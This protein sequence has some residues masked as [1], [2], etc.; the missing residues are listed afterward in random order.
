MPNYVPGYQYDV[1]ISYSHLNNGEG[2]VNKFR[3]KLEARLKERLPEGFEL[4]RD[5]EELPGNAELTPEITDAVR[6]TAVLVPVVS[7]GFLKSRW[8]RQECEEFLKACATRGVRDCV[9]PVRYDDVDPVEYRKVVGERVGYEFFARG[10]DDKYTDTLQ[11]GSR[12]F[13]QSLNTLR[14]EIARQLVELKTRADSEAMRP[15]AIA[16]ASAAVPGGAGDATLPRSSA[17]APWVAGGGAGP[18][19]FLAAPSPGLDDVADQFVSFLRGYDIEVIRP[20]PRFYQFA[21]YE[22]AFDA[23]LNRALVFVQLLG[24]RFDPHPDDAVQSWDRWQFLRAEAARL[25]SFRWFN[26]HNR[27]GSEIDVQQLDAD[28]RAFVR[29]PGVWDFQPGQF[30]E[31]VRTEVVQRFHDLRQARRNPGGKDWQPLIVLRAER[32]DQAV[33]D[34]IGAT[35]RGLKC[36]W[37]RVPDKAVG[38]F[39]DFVAQYAGNGLLVVY[40]ACPGHWVLTRLQELRKFLQ[41][42]MG[43]R[44]ACGLWRAPANDED[45]LNCSMDGLFLIEPRD[46]RQLEQFV[47]AM[48]LRS[49]PPTSTR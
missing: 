9:F 35:L 25:P 4:F 12:G 23:G 49:Q 18:T 48:R 41:T 28:H 20:E 31:L 46:P 5:R 38:S 27:D 36:D 34:E 10:E 8:C 42:E 47:A 26:K 16:G 45:T 19:V 39:E 40:R 2:W 3:A 17:V 44:W 30:R 24:R 43:R 6:H 13:Q 21:G 14:V 22:G 32:S 7:H 37:L 33:A 1:F 15:G 11:V 29:Q